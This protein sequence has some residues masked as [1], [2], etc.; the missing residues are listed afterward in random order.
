MMSCAPRH[1]KNVADDPRSAM[2]VDQAISH[3]YSSQLRVSNV[4]WLIKQIL[5][6]RVHSHYLLYHGR[7]LPHMYQWQAN[8]CMH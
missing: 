7:C 6:L 1:L 2:I 5:T 8:L 3:L 4:Y